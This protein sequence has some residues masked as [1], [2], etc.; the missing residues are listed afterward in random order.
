MNSKQIDEIAVSYL[1]ITLAKCK[2][3]MPDIN[4]NDKTPVW[5]GEIQL[6]GNIEHTR[7]WI[8]K[9]PVQVKGTTIG[10]LSNSKIA[11][12]VKKS[13]LENFSANGGVMFFVILINDDGH[14][15]F[16]KRLLPQDIQPIIKEMS[17]TWGTHHFH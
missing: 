12:S 3:L 7:G 14:K 2:L 17:L 4:T 15:I 11:H 6:F 5:D 10:D 8:R 13:N 16:Y 1:N 9:I